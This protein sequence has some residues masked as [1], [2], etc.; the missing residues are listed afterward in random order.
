M[1]E[2]ALVIEGSPARRVCVEDCR[3]VNQ[4]LPV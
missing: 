3:R 2:Q 1:S 4:L